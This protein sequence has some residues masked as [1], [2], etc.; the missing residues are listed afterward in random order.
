M[1]MLGLSVTEMVGMTV[2]METVTM[3][4]GGRQNMTHAV[5]L[6]HEI[7]SQTFVLSKCLFYIWGVVLD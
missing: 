6:V 4:G 5:Y 2:Q 3:I 7:K 1:G